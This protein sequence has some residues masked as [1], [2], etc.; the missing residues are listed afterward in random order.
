MTTAEAIRKARR[1]HDEAEE[2]ADGFIVCKCG[3]SAFPDGVP[4]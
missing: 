4:G 2:S 1:R 3:T